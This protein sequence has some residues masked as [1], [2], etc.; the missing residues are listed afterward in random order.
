MRFARLGL[1]RYGGFTDRELVF[2]P[3]AR[4][5]VIEG[6]NEAGKSTAL[7]AA[8]DVL[9]GIERT[10]P[11][12]FLHRYKD[13][14]LSA[15]VLGVDGRAFAFIRVK[16]DRSTLL[17][18]LTDAPLPDD[19]LAPFLGTHQRGSF[20]EIFGLDQKRLRKGGEDLLAGGGELA[21]ALVTA[22]PGLR[23]IDALRARYAEEAGKVFNPARKTAS[24]LFY[25]ALD[26]RK[27][28]RQNIRE[29]E[30]LA[31]DVRRLRSA[32]EAALLARAA[33]VEADMAAAQEAAWAELLCRAAGVLRQI[34]AEETALAALGALPDM[35]AGFVDKAR[36]ALAALETAT[37]ALARAVA[38]EARADAAHGAVAVDT[39]ILDLSAEAEAC[40]EARAA[41]NKAREDL[42]RRRARAAEARALLARIAAD[43]GLPD[44]DTLCAGLPPAPLLA[45]AEALADRFKACSLGAQA[46]A[47]GLEEHARELAR[48]EAAQAGL[49]PVEDPAPLRRRLDALDGAEERARGLEAGL[50]R[51][52]AAG[53]AL[54]G[55]V[56]RLGQ[57][58]LT[59]D[60]LAILPLP[61]VAAAEALLRQV[62]ETAEARARQ[63]AAIADLAEQKQLAAARHAALDGGGTAPTEA[64]VAAARAVR[65][66]LWQRLRPL[67]LGERPAGDADRDAAL[68][69]DGALAAADRVAD[70]RQRETHRLAELS[71]LARDM[72]DL[73]LRL[74]AAGG[75]RGEADAQAAAA[76]AAW[77]SLF[78]A[79]GL[80]FPADA[81]AIAFLKD[82][83]AIREA[84]DELRRQEA[85]GETARAAVA[86]D[87]TSV[88]ALRQDLGLAAL[89]DAPLRMAE[90]RDAVERLERQHRDVRDQARDLARLA[91]TRDDLAR[92]KADLDAER[93]ALD[94]EAADVL[95]RLA[96]RPGAP[97]EEMRAALGLWRSAASETAGLAGVEHQISAIERDEAAFAGRV[98]DLARRTG[99]DPAGDPIALARHLR[100]RLEEARQ[101]SA[102][103]QAARD[104]L[105][106]RRAAVAEATRERDR[107]HAAVA[108]LRASAGAVPPDAF[109]AVLDRLDAASAMA[110][111]AEEARRRLADMCRGRDVAAVRAATAGHDDAT[112]AAR[113]EEA[114]AAHALARAARDEAVAR[115]AEAEAALRALDMREGAAHA[116][117]AEQDAAAAIAEAVEDFGRNHVAARL[118]GRAIERY[119]EAHQNPIVSRAAQAFATL[120]L[121]RW[122]GIGV[123][124]EAATPRLGAMRAGEF[125]GVEKLSEGT[126]DQLFLALRVAAIEEHA[127]RATPLPFMADDLFVTFDEART[128]AGLKL[129]AE[130]GALTQVIVFTHHAHVGEAAERALGAACQRIR[131]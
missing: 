78:T 5:V 54:D 125:H 8:G 13:M 131:L 43:L 4:L 33:A 119:R 30:L 97:A 23:R 102:R 127:R 77:A 72:A 55:R 98:A 42:P 63:D 95:P 111:R 39:V 73:D 14:R 34:E 1:D 86:F 7:R 79:S 53:T 69:L 29:Q 48:V 87:R 67:A 32:A 113:A 129:L 117:Q 96:I 25:Q 51:R 26:A 47:S 22:A 92:R 89:G 126:A 41:V 82:V 83:E 109:A 3:A 104:A 90:I 40:D 85:E 12:N 57:P 21:D 38:E 68:D 56:L 61:A 24:H 9:F 112:L 65:D 15:T 99:E 93:A 105:D 45:R 128:E 124:Y 10:S 46:L 16:R 76:R 121:G 37:A 28:A 70:E 101:A 88:A 49:G 75:R 62:V 18:P 52:A 31:V 91:R 27:A 108:A 74:G 84:R 50:A 115:H 20:L 100:K 80:S 114:G 17:D 59:L 106:A 116:A 107:A 110:G 58:G 36:A 35:P 130:L 122:S 120:T 103:A 64:A 6:A 19:A 44:V 118:L 123:D 81:R 11:F 66:G 94:A 2:D 60:A 71:R